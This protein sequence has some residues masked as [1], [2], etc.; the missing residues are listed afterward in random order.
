[1]SFETLRNHAHQI[2]RS[3]L[4]AVEPK[5]AIR[6]CVRRQGDHLTLGERTFDLSSFERV[7]VIGA[8]KAGAPMAAALEE[9]LDTHLTDGVIIVKYH[10]LEP[11]RR[12][13]LIEAGHP[14]PDA[15]SV[16]ATKQV[17]KLARE[18]GEKDLVLCL[19]SGGGSALLSLP[20]SGITLEEKQET[21]ER[22]LKSGASINEINAVRKHVSDVKGGQL[23]QQVYPA[24]L[25]TL[26]LSD[27][28][29]DPLDVIASGPTVP[30]SS[31]FV[32]VDR[33]ISNFH[34]GELLPESIIRHIARGRNGEIPETP[35]PGD[36]HF[37]KTVNIVVGS[38]RQAVE[39][40]QRCAESFGYHT[41][42]LSTFIEGET[43]EIAKVHAAI[44]REILTSGRPIR[45]PACLISGGETTV[46]VHGEG[47]GGRNQEFV[48]ASA[49]AIQGV[50][51]VVIFSAGTDGTD[52]PTDAAG[53]ICDGRTISRAKAL[54]LDSR[55]HLYD[56]NAYPYF[57]KLNDLVLTGPTNTNVMDL[58]LVLVGDKI[59]AKNQ[60][61]LYDRPGD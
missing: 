5:T 2:F 32:D 47:K 9:I 27:V 3:A 51:P 43:R 34:L 6:T 55:A 52:G 42:V 50:E 36:V 12:I 24:T 18:A 11:L 19:I 4:N 44:A 25:V 41:L 22:L 57:A 35:K 1:M 30:D 7:F 20:V 49:I 40:A 58:R 53:A 48:L 15:A 13:R 28:I 39:A 54:G 14:I 38:N 17:L 10:H 61:R 46:T 59:D 33:I 60:N 8:G 56:N 21:T 29:G 45:R 37:S 16:D 26:I 23:A 31:T